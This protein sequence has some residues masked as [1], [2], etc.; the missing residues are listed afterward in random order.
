MTIQISF[1]NKIPVTKTQ[2]YDNKKAQ[3][4]PAT[5]YELDCKDK[6][7]KDYDYLAQPGVWSY[8]HLVN[9]S[10]YQKY[11]N[12]ENYDELSP[13][14]KMLNKGTKIYA[15]EA[16][17]KE[18]KLLGFIQTSGLHNFDDIVFLETLHDGSYRYCGQALIASCV[19]RLLKEDSPELTVSDPEEN[20]STGYS[21]VPFYTDKCYFKKLSEIEPE[22]KNDTRTL[23][24]RQ[25]GM[26]NFIQKFEQRT[27]S[28]VI[29]LTA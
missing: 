1:G 8:K 7:Y 25:D 20:P 4:V 14:L 10:L 6:D 5:V 19:Q 16:D 11:K 17:E 23:T 27:Q 26:Q 18:D 22:T 12:Y 24:L 2:I 28:P 21:A 9:N 29:D 13:V 3:Y 15:I